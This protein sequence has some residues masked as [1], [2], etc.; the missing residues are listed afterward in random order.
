MGGRL[1]ATRLRQPFKDLTSIL[2]VQ[3]LVAYLHHLDSARE[4]LR[5][6]LDTVYDLE[7]LCTRIVV[8][9]STPKDL[10]R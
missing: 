7:R 5:R 3:E 10:A 1:L 9:R 8:N 2:P 4:D 6:L